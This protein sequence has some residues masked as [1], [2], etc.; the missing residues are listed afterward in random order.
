MPAQCCGAA[1]PAPA[2]TL[3]EVIASAHQRWARL[4]LLDLLLQWEQAEDLEPEV[5]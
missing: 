1:A 3:A 4:A 2:V 5:A